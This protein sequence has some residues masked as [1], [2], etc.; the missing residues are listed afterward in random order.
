MGK[1]A[2]FY[3]EL[4]CLCSMYTCVAG[5]LHLLCGFEWRAHAPAFLRHESLQYGIQKY[6]GRA[7]VFSIALAQARVGVGASSWGSELSSFLQLVY[8][9]WCC[10][11]MPL[12]VQGNRWGRA[13]GAVCVLFL[14]EWWD[15]NGAHRCMCVASNSR[16]IAIPCG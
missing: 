7:S 5:S 1:K 6:V 10:S 13:P 15:V 14:H 11:L 9:L 3:R 12:W 4:S 2:C 8:L 16:G